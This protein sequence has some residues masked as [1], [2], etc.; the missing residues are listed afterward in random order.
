[1]NSVLKLLSAIKDKIE[2]YLSVM[3]FQKLQTKKRKKA[4]KEGTNN[5]TKQQ[6]IKESKNTKGQAERKNK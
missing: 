2:K 6:K 1:M 4:W 3:D 5:K